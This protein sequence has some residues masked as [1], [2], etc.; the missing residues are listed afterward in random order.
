L[1]DVATDA[2]DLLVRQLAMQCRALFY[3]W[4]GLFEL[5][6]LP[7]AAPAADITIIDDDVVGDPVFAFSSASEIYNKIW[8]FYR[9]DYRSSGASGR[10]GQLQSGLNPDAVARGY[11]DLKEVVDGDED[12]H[13]DLF[14]NAVRDATHAQDVT[15]YYLNRYKNPRRTIKCDLN[16]TGIAAAPGD[17]MSYDDAVFGSDIYQITQF[18]PDVARG[19]VS[20]EGVATP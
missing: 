19:I 13:M 10:A 9:R 1:H 14:L 8:G 18:Q 20:V 4:A 15:T 12:L 16:W 2:Q 5:Q 7:D 3:E 17:F 11:L 6:Y